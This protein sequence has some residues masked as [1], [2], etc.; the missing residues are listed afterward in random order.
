MTKSQTAAVG[1]WVF[2]MLRK[3]TP[4]ARVPGALTPA[5]ISRD[6]RPDPTMRRNL[7]VSDRHHPA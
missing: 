1:L 3:L 4:D 5:A 2:S 7:N 6:V